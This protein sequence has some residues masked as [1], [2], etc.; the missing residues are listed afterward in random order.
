MISRAFEIV[1]WFSKQ[2]FKRNLVVLWRF[3]RQWCLSNNL[4]LFFIHISLMYLHF[5]KNIWR[6]LEDIYKILFN[7]FIR[8]S[9]SNWEQSRSIDSTKKLWFYRIA[10]TRD[11]QIIDWCCRR[12]VH[13]LR[14]LESITSH[15]NPIHSDVWFQFHKVPLEFIIGPVVGY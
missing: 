6:F 12:C 8:P 7:F 3:L 2:F 9:M 14:L 11:L 15:V 10:F 13:R 4:S 5:Q 1:P